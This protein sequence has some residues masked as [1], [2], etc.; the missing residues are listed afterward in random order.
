[1]R[2]VARYLAVAALMFWL[3]GFTFY[4]GV[5]VPAGTKVLQ[6][7]RE[8]GFITREVTGWLNVAG[9]AGLGLLAAEQLA[10]RDPSRSRWWWRAALLAV[11]A[12]CQV[13]LF[14]LHGE[15]DRL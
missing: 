10:G 2:I 11:M 8:Q 1:M 13:W 14:V 9:A 5:V 3:G 15:L 12:A 4:A 6:S 7:G